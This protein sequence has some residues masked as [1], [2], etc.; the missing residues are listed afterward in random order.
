MTVI[1]CKEIRKVVGGYI[2]EMRWPYGGEPMGY[3]EVVCETWEEV[4]GKLTTAADQQQK[5]IPEPDTSRD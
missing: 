1:V 3:G 4:I 5:P 2:I